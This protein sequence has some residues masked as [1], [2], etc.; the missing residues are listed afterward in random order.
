MLLTQPCQLLKGIN[1]SGDEFIDLD[2]GD[3]GHLDE[4]VVLLPLLFAQLAPVTQV[5]VSTGHWIGSTVHPVRCFQEVGFDLAVVAVI[6]GQ[7]ETL[8]RTVTKDEMNMENEGRKIMG[9]P[10]FRASVTCVRVPVFRSHSISVTAAFS[11]AVDVEE[12]RRLID[13]AP[14]VRVTDNPEEGVYPTPLDATGIDDCLVGRIR[15][16]IVFENGL[17]F[18]VVGDQVRKGAALNTVQIAEL[19]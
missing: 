6:V 9:L 3:I 17:S 11:K 19:L 1:A 15:K 16:D 5:A 7:P 4:M 12:A 10:E 13:A 8:F 18:W 2:P 14:G